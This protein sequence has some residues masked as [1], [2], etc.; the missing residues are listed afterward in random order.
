MGVVTGVLSFEP[1]PPG[2]EPVLGLPKARPGRPPSP[3]GGGKAAPSHYRDLTL[4]FTFHSRPW[5]HVVRVKFIPPI[6][7]FPRLNEKES[8]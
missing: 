5:D 3:Q 1:P 7:E 2:P 4:P 6:N 8:R